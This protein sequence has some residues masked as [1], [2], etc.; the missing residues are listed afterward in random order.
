VEHLAETGEDNG[1]RITSSCH[2]S[3]RVSEAGRP[4]FSACLS[5]GCGFARA[6]SAQG[7]G[8]AAPERCRHCSVRDWPPERHMI[9]SHSPAKGSLWVRR[10]PSTRFLRSCSRYKVRSPAVGSVMLPST[11][12]FPAV[13]RSTE[14]TRRGAEG[15]DEIKG[16]QPTAQWKMACCNCSS[17]W[18]R[19]MGSS[20]CAT[21]SSSCCFWAGRT[22]DRSS[23]WRGVL[24]ES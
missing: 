7:S 1:P 10:Q 17:C 18:K 12:S 9:C 21:S 19:R 20:V 15:R 11:G 8:A 16:E 4:V 13:H 14:K 23:R 24:A 3:S 2:C 6:D 5:V 22:P